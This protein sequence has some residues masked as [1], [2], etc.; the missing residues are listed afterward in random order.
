[1]GLV[2]GSDSGVVGGACSAAL[3]AGDQDG[4]YACSDCLSVRYRTFADSGR[5]VA[6]D[7]HV[8]VDARK[9]ARRRRIFD[10]EPME[11]YR[12]ASA[13]SAAA[14]LA[15][16]AYIERCSRPDARGD[17]ATPT[18]E[19]IMLHYAIVFLVIAL[20]AGILGFGGIAGTAAGIAKLL[21]VVFIV[22]FLGSLV[23]GR[24]RTT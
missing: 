23:M 24:R 18:G 7:L 20:I 1:V 17:V 2:A 22:L 11:S 9:P 15:A 10:V 4:A 6:N 3:D 16:R 19:P 12:P 14:E 21:F 8:F 5:S 13:A